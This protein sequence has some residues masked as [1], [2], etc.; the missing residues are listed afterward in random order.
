LPPQQSAPFGRR[1]RQPSPIAR[2]QFPAKGTG[3]SSG[4]PQDE[5][6]VFEARED[7]DFLMERFVG[8]DWADYQFLWRL[9]RS[10]GALIPSFSFVAFS[11]SFAWLFYRRLYLAGLAAM[12]LQIEVTRHSSLG[13]ILG[14]LLLAAGV[15]FFGKALVLRKGMK[16]IRANRGETGA[17]IASLGGTRLAPAVFSV[18]LV[19]AVSVAEYAG[20]IAKKLEAAP[21]FSENG[22]LALL[23]AL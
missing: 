15:G 8:P 1:G 11:F 4:Q 20:Q 19:T 12:A 18:A 16:I 3:F 22:F 5:A 17:R 23:Q 10:N 21:A 7:D 6:N 14:G 9:M 13:S 2:L